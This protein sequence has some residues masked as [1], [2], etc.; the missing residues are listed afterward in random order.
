MRSVKTAEKLQEARTALDR[1]ETESSLVRRATLYRTGFRA[2]QEADRQGESAHSELI[3]NLRVTY[4]RAMIRDLPT[5]R[6]TEPR[7]WVDLL[8]ALFEVKEEM[9][10]QIIADPVLEAR[11]A[12]FIRV[13]KDDVVKAL[14]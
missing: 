12:A 2:L 3:A 8:R 14:G 10:R 4:V 9:A 7:A 6:S 5:S 11:Y 1:A 13:F